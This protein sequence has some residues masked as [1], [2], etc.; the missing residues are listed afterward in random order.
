MSDKWWI[1]FVNTFGHI[2]H[3]W[4]LL[5]TFRPFDLCGTMEIQ[6]CQLQADQPH[7]GV[8]DCKRFFGES[9]GKHLKGTHLKNTQYLV[10]VLRLQ[11][12]SIVFCG[13]F[14]C[15]RKALTSGEGERWGEE[16]M[17]VKLYIVTASLTSW[18]PLHCVVISIIKLILLDHESHCRVHD[19]H[20]QKKKT[21]EENRVSPPPH[22]RNEN[23]FPFLLNQQRRSILNVCHCVNLWWCD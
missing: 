10:N 4:T 22:K 17:E 6:K 16:E 2:G 7:T 5:D 21:P 9:R 19:K 11:L 23:I 20:F 18:D 13:C 15:D 8:G 12:I 3:F 1:L 14:F